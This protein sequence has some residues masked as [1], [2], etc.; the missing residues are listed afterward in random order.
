MK[1]TTLLVI[2]FL[3]ALIA[4]HACLPGEEIPD[5]PSGGV[6]DEGG[7][8]DTGEGEAEK[9]SSTIFTREKA[10]ML[11]SG[12]RQPSFPRKVPSLYL[13]KAGSTMPKTM[14]TST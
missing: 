10:D 4:S 12:S 14:A 5:S 9:I 1:K 6:V 13:L 7:G 8:G 3:S 11:F 2:T